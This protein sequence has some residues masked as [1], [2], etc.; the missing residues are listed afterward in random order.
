MTSEI[1]AIIPS[2]NEEARIGDAITSIVRQTV[3]VSRI[4]VASDN[5]TDATVAIARSWG[6]IVEVMETVGNRHKKSGALEQ[7]LA[8]IDAPDDTFILVMDA[9]SRIVPTFVEEALKAFVPGVG[10]VGG[11]FVG[12]GL[13]GLIGECQS[14]EYIRYAREIGRDR[15]RARVL[16]GTSTMTRLG[17]FREVR[18]ARE[19]GILPGTGTYSRHALTEDFEMTL[20]IRTLGYRTMSP[21]G[22]RVVTETM[23]D[24]RTLW[25]QRIRWQRGAIQ[26]LWMYGLSRVTLPYIARQIEV[27]IGLVAMALLWFLT[28]WS[29]ADGSLVVHPAW[30]CLGA[31]FQLE[32]L[33][34]GWRAGW[35]GRLIAGTMVMDMM[36]DLFIGAVY[37]CSVWQTLTGKALVWGASTI[38]SAERA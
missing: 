36:F 1:I 6:G 10:A 3:P 24:T 19:A 32:R 29:L 30:L 20:A 7:A 4:L 16:T 12:D 25:R 35:K 23:P 27:G 31:V 13:N 33:V 18:A 34:S 9:D 26:A 22:C 17:T 11:I 2:H 15:A 8:T 21:K 38:D 37:L 14:L 5:S 28:G